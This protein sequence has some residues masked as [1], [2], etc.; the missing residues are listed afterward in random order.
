MGISD[1]IETFIMELLKNEDDFVEVGRNELASIFQCVPSQINYVIKT[2][3]SPQRGYIVESKRG[4]GG[5]LRIRR[6]DAEEETSYVLSLIG[7]SIDYQNGKALIGYLYQ[8]GKINASSAE[9]MLA[10]ISDKSLYAAGEKKNNVRAQ[11]L[12]NMILISQN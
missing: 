11:C 7:D 9:I 12:K 4:G 2:R 8:K 10:G 5:C 3:F 6:I 1:R